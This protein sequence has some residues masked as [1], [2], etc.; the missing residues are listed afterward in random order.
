MGKSSQLAVRL[1]L[2]V[3]VGVGKIGFIHR[4]QHSTL[5]NLQKWNFLISFTTITNKIEIEVTPESNDIIAKENL[6]IVLDNTGN[7]TLTLIEDTISSGSN[8]SGTTYTPPSS[9]ISTKKYTR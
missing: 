3:S 1:I 4:S 8:R 5:A 2:T 9:F 6:Y 7:S